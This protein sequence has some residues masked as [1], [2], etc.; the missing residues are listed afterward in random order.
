M[1]VGRAMGRP[2]TAGAASDGDAKTAEVQA[3]AEATAA[4][5][6]GG[7]AE[8]GV[9]EGG[10]AEGVAEGQAEASPGAQD[11]NEEEAE[12]GLGRIPFGPFLA[13]GALE[14]LFFGRQ[15]TDAYLAW[16]LP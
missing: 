15:I 4:G 12:G 7:V 3:G 14:F 10:V 6:D 1:L 16:A 8:G 2:I 13:L 5:A 9:A 11:E